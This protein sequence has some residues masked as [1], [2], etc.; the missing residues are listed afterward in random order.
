MAVAVHPAGGVPRAARGRGVTTGRAEVAVVGGSGIDVSDLLTDPRRRRVTTRYGEA[1]SVV[2]RLAGRPVAFLPRH[3]P[4]HRVPPHRINYRANV[5]A[6]VELGARRVVATA[7]VGSLD[8]DLAPGT[9]VLVDQ[10]LDFTRGRASTFHDGGQDGVVHVDV[11][12]P[13]CP[14]I[15]QA[16]REVAGPAGL[17]VRDGGT[18]VCTEGPRFETAAEIRAFRTLGGDVVGMTGVPEV[19]L[20]RELGLCYATLAVVTNLAAG[21][22]PGRLSHEEVLGAQAD[23]A[24]RLAALLAA[25]V[26]DLPAARGCECHVRPGI[27]GE[28]APPVEGEP[29]PVDRDASPPG[30][31]PTPAERDGTAPGDDPSSAEPEEP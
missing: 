20:A 6:L 30:G 27:L 7:A 19:V 23:R 24:E 5:A 2:G 18:Y 29:T 22:R 15:R 28:Q 21:L 12:D 11:S 17:P 25:V 31:E 8:P 14:E 13:Y 26:G 9:L 1:R 16:A 4:G 3:G 10:F